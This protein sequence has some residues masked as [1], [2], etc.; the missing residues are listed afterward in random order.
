MSNQSALAMA[1]MAS[2]G[3]IG[4]AVASIVAAATVGGIA[5]IVLNIIVAAIAVFAMLSVG[6]AQ[7]QINHAVKVC[8]EVDNGDFEARIVLSTAGGEIKQLHETLNNLID[9]CDAFIREASTSMEYVANNMY[10]RKI[11]EKGMT[12]SFRNGAK[13]TNKAVENMHQKIDDFSGVANNFE[14]TIHKIVDTVASAATEL[15][16]SAQSMSGTATAT[17]EKAT[18]VAA[19]TEEASVSVQTVASAAEELSSS[20]AEISRQAAQSSTSSQAAVDETLETNE[21]IKGLSEAAKEIGEVVK[22]ITDIADQTNLLALNATIEA[23]RAG[24]AGKGFAVVASEVKNL[25]NQT[26]KATEEI[27]E[28]IGAIQSHTDNA[29]HAMD[30][31]TKTMS[32]I[33]ES[34]TSIASAVEQQG[35]ATKEIAQSVEQASTGTNE[36]ATHIVDVTSGAGETGHASGEVLTA[37]DELSKQAETLRSEVGTFFVAM[38]KVI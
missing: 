27:S 13:T 34:A 22:L 23:A 6:K 2:I 14:T 10:F 37:A 35:A 38:R 4:A 36:V 31:I 21:K 33:N 15:H 1:K 28:R 11:I 24:D 5:T 8:Q 20:I 3:V 17:S 16:A 9:R 18:A 29:V 12:G 25:A 32:G 30:G 19:A 26:S 7:G